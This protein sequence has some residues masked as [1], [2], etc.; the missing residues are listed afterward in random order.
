MNKNVLDEK[1]IEIKTV[2]EEG[3]ERQNEAGF[4]EVI[5]CKIVVL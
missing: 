2:E 4:E 5:L 1:K 3:D